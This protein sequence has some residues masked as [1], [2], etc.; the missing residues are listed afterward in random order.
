MR[1]SFKLLFIGMACA[2]AI[3]VQAAEKS[4]RQVVQQVCAACHAEGKDGA[5]KI[6]DYAA[7]SKRVEKGFD[8][9]AANAITGTGKMPAHGGQADLT[10]LEMSR[11]IAYMAYG[12]N[13]KDTNK[14]YASPTTIAGDKLV[15]THCVNCHGAGVAGAPK[16][17]T[18]EDWKPRLD[19][20]LDA[21]VASAIHGHKAMPSRAGMS[22]LSDTDIRNAVTFM[23]IQS[24]VHQ[25]K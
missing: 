5:P 23:L 14:A 24:A 9:L 10:D 20:G 8:K 25:S 3:P 22:R 17:G 13:S 11:A 15:K 21:L 19:K 1:H 6:G 7:W 18:F 4:G 2:L 16:L 12:G